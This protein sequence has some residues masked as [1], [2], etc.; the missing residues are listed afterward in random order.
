MGAAAY[1]SKQRRPFT[2]VAIYRNIR[3][4]QPRVKRRGIKNQK[5]LILIECF[6]QRLAGCKAGILL[7]C[8]NGHDA[9]NHKDGSKNDLPGYGFHASKE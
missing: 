8:S 9:G 1:E 3:D 5:P 6:S 7:S 2:G 4:W